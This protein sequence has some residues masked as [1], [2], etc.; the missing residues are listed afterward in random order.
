MT[1]LKKL[2]GGFNRSFWS[3]CAAL[4][5]NQLGA[6][7]LTYLG[8]YLI[9]EQGLSVAT[10]G[11][12]LTVSGIGGVVCQWVGGI[13]VDRL[14][15]RSVMAG[16]MSLTGF[17]LLL[18]G[19]SDELAIIAVCT[20]LVG[21]TAEMYRPAVSAMVA[22]RFS[23]QELPR[24]YSFV[25]WA[26]NLGYGCSMILGGILVRHGYSSL[27]YVNSA[28]CIAAGILVRYSIPKESSARE[29]AE[30]P[31]LGGFSRVL[32]DRLMLGYLAVTLCYGVV[33]RQAGTTLPIAMG[34]DGLSP[35]MFGFI[36]GINAVVIVVFQPLSVPVVSR[37]DPNRVLILGIIFLGAGFGLTS[38]A[39]SA[40]EYSGTVIIWS[41]GE[42]AVS[43]VNQ[44]IVAALAPPHLRGRYYG[45]YGMVWATAMLLAPLLGTRL[46]EHG[47]QL[48]WS[49]CAGLCVVAVSG[50]LFMA[51]RIRSRESN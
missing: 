32:R 10:S 21:A 31:E 19:A 13:L 46:L 29:K 9:Q 25:Y 44:A 47:P 43:S 15:Y 37:M 45:L 12:I 3:V 2:V 8:Y 36:M 4:F 16:S 33:F 11:T 17:A 24:A 50:H 26:V 39:S 40:I 1:Q 38:A 18:L 7:V 42:I 28:T 22:H 41:L 23:P 14:G 48:L 6:M 49:I 5:T 30:D 51:P 20:F 27:F 34:L 35:S